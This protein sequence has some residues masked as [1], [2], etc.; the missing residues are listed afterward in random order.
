MVAGTADLSVS[1][2]LKMSW[3]EQGGRSRVGSLA[4][5]LLQKSS[6]NVVKPSC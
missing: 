3:E 5:H 2:R 6:K 4:M 1:Q